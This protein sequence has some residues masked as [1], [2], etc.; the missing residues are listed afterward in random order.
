[1]EKHTDNIKPCCWVI[2]NWLLLS[3][4]L[5]HT[6]KKNIQKCV[7]WDSHV[8]I[9]RPSAGGN[10]AFESITSPHQDL[11]CSV[12]SAFLGFVYIGNLETTTA[13]MVLKLL[14]QTWLSPGFLSKTSRALSPNH[15]AFAPLSMRTR[16]PPE[17]SLHYAPYHPSDTQLC[18]LQYRFTGSRGNVEG[19]NFFQ[20]HSSIFQS[21]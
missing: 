19:R 12:I 5:W 11:S 2:K 16:S 6:I 21:L 14:L 3:P 4:L 7:S 15:H 17:P 8:L 1:M 18:S 13:T 9:I 20:S 10:T